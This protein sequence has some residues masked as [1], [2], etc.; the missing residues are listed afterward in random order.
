MWYAFCYCPGY[1]TA[2]IHYCTFAL[3]VTLCFVSFQVFKAVDYDKKVRENPPE[4]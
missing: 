4:Y 1:G 3:H 2:V